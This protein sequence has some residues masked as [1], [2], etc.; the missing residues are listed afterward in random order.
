MAS[1]LSFIQQA[2]SLLGRFGGNNGCSFTVSC[3]GDALVLPVIPGRYEVG[4]SYNNGSVNVNALGEI[5]MLGKRN[6]MTI[7]FSSF[8]P[9]QQYEFSAIGYYSPYEGIRKLQSFAQ[10]GQPCKLLISGTDINTAVTIDSLNYREK[11]GTGDVYFD[12]SMREY[13]YILPTSNRLNKTTQLSSRVAESLQER[14]V[15]LY[16][17]M[18]LMDA[19]SEAVGQIFPISEQG[20]KKLLLYKHLVKLGISSSNSFKVT[21]CRLTIGDVSIRL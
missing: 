15:T 7:S 21:R 2:S 11:D 10:K 9:A 13:R 4:Q 1:F 17:G 5:N 3:A 20:N 18:D 8:F 19:A 14:D 16:P 12:L 6:L